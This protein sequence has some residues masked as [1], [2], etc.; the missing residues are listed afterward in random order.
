M[1]MN[2]GSQNPVSDYHQHHSIYTSSI[3]PAYGFIFNS[4]DKLYVAFDDRG[5]Y[6][7]L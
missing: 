4:Y 2:I 6:E 5:Q 1:A 3:L 7:D